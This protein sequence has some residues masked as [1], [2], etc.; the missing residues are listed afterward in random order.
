MK[1]ACIAVCLAF[2]ACF[3]MPALSL[4]DSDFES[5]QGG[6]TSVV[7]SADPLNSYEQTFNVS[8][9]GEL[10]AAVA[11][12]N[13]AGAGLYCVVLGADFTSSGFTLAGN[14]M[15][16]LGDGHTLTLTGKIVVT[17][18]V[19]SLGSSDE[20][21]SLNLVTAAYFAGFVE[22]TG[23]GSF[24]NVYTGV[25]VDGANLAGCVRVGGG[26]TMNMYGGTI[27]RGA[28]VD[29]ECFGGVYVSGE[30]TFNLYGGLISDCTS[31]TNAGGV[32][33]EGNKS[34]FN[35]K[36]GKISGCST[37]SFGGGVYLGSN[38]DFNMYSGTI[39]DCSARQGGGVAAND[40]NISSNVVFTMNGGKIEGCSATSSGGGIFA[41]KGTVFLVR[42]NAVITQCSAPNGGGYRIE[43]AMSATLSGES[44]C[45]GNTATVAGDDVS[46]FSGFISLDTV[47]VGKVL[48]GDYL[49]VNDWY[50]DS[51]GARWSL[52]GGGVPAHLE[53]LKSIP[54]N[55]F[56][57]AAFKA[58]YDNP[59]TLSF[60]LKSGSPAPGADYD[61]ATI[62]SGN[63]VVLPA[64]PVRNGYKFRGWYDNEQGTG[65]AYT[66]SSTMPAHDLNLYAVYDMLFTLSYN[67]CGG[68]GAPGETYDSDKY[69][70][71]DQIRIPAD[72]TWEDH[73][74]L[75]WFDNPECTGDAYVAGSVMPAGPLSLYAGWKQSDHTLSFSPNGGA[76]PETD[77]VIQS[78][79]SLTTGSSLVKPSANPVRDGFVFM[80]WNTA[81]DGT[82]DTFDSEA[83]MPAANLSFYA[84]W[85]AVEPEPTPGT[86]PDPAP[87]DPSGTGGDSS[88]GA[89]GQSADGPAASSALT[90]TGDGMVVSVLGLILTLLLGLAVAIVA[91]RRM[92]R[93]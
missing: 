92:K 59:F 22:A 25:L 68:T 9:D 55:V 54:T 33:V 45:Y 38:S 71:G 37:G 35:M 66:T 28:K 89:S 27:T 16:L 4:A 80:G 57:P 14:E 53:R 46:V 42:Y 8:N 62:T 81:S 90:T 43:D 70:E 75:G 72:P 19:L 1:K 93:R 73:D 61:D 63:K 47:P 65:E 44:L 51:A 13:T 40:S 86:D 29:I 30:A 2:V 41:G 58:A 36:G 52:G 83:T 24:I 18:G 88:A 91:G 84:V 78:E 74:F 76:F 15:V 23:S 56:A 10:Q 32:R 64:G 60:D 21:D 50:D 31:N 26:A 49:Q 82:G 5:A 17:D 79:F 77:P 67:L 39:S 48:P 3:A 20:S 7:S 6:A 12:I 85:K 34:T 87:V 69:I 11:Q